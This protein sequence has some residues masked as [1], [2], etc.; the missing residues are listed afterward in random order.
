MELGGD[1]AADLA[2][3]GTNTSSITSKRSLERLGYLDSCHIPGVTEKD[4]PLM[5]KYVV[6]KPSRRSPV[7]NRAYY[8]RTESIR[9]LLEG[10]IDECEALGLDQCAVVSLGCGFDPMFFRQA[11][12]RKH[13]NSRTRLKY[14]D[15]D[16]PSLILERLYMIRNEATLRALLPE[17][18]SRDDVE[19][20][21]S[22]SYACL[23][24]DLRQLDQLQKGLEEAGIKKDSSERMPILVISEVVLAYLEA[25]ESDAVI[26]FFA[27]YPE[28]TFVLH[29]QCIPD[30]DEAQESSNLHPFALTMFRHFERTMTPLKTLQEYRSLKDHR[31]RFETLGWGACDVLN[32]NLISDY[33]TMPTAAH[34][35]RVSMLEPFDEHDELYWIGAF[36]FIAVAMT[37]HHSPTTSSSTKS[38]DVLQYVGL[39]QRLQ[40]AKT[41]AS[42][43]VDHGSYTSTNSTIDPILA[44]RPPA[45]ATYQNVEWT[46]SQ[47]FSG[48]DLHRKGHTLS[49]LK[50][51][52]Y[53]FGG[54]GS[55]VEENASE[56]AQRRIFQTRGQ[57]T[58]LGSMLRFHLLNGSCQLVSPGTDD[59]A[60]SP[61]M[62]HSA[63]TTLDGSALYLYGG[64]DG[65]TKVH[66]DVWRYTPEDGW[67]PLWRARISHSGDS[68]VPK[69]LFKHTANIMHVAGREMMVIVG[70]RLASGEANDQIWAF[71]LQEGQWGHFQWRQNGA[72]PHPLEDRIPGIFS[73]SAVVVKGNGAEQQ[74][75]DSLLIVGGIR[76][77]DEKVLNKVWK[78]TLG[79]SEGEDPSCWVE[80]TALDIHTSAGEALKPRFGHACVHV[81]EDRIWVL[82]GVSAPGLLQWHESLLEIQPSTGTFQYLRPSSFRELVMVGHAAALDP[83]R[84]RVVGVGGGGT[85]FGFGAWWDSAAWALT[86]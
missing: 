62:H 25:G 16:Y 13:R 65:P 77:A 67:D 26:Q 61:R 23:G 70:G 17:N 3:Q 52:A 64:R 58:R 44:L 73:H 33:L 28:A 31:D 41:L 66:N 27:Q 4:T 12:L 36:Y 38:P 69:G 42:D 1:Q 40:Q 79:V 60:P 34:H 68:A 74:Q 32:M 9:L 29:E 51:H 59:E 47:P 81:S 8:Q 71:D 84:G 83:E 63:A 22:D 46:D 50:D 49:V 72:T 21:V 2:I 76:G 57:Q 56:D 35:H 80:A 48:Q 45:P 75:Q 54:F 6:P 20:F 85:C 82:G 78:V 5:F 37:T 53:V 24:I 14:V 55:E 86:T 7:I 43:H 15:I 11:T 19:A 10:W 39:R 30:F 18:P